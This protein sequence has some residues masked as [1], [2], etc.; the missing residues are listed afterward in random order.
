MAKLGSQFV[1]VCLSVCLSLSRAIWFFISEH[2]PSFLSAD[3][4]LQV[5]SCPAVTMFTCSQFKVVSS[6]PNPSFP[7]ENETGP[8]WV[9][10]HQ[11]EKPYVSAEDER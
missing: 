1:S 2:L 3:C 7:R 11:Q 8:I 9:G 6:V 5:H 4:F 10:V